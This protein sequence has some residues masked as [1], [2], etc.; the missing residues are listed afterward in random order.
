MP[1]PDKR[2]EAAIEA[3]ARDAFAHDDD[4]PTDAAVWAELSE[5][6]R[7]RYRKEARAAYDAARG[8]PKHFEWPER[9]ELGEHQKTTCG[10]ELADC[11]H[12]SYRKEVTCIVCLQRIADALYGTPFAALAE[13]PEPR[14][15]QPVAEQTPEQVAAEL[16]LSAPAGS[17]PGEQDQ[18]VDRAAGAE[19]TVKIEVGQTWRH[20]STGDYE[21]LF[22][23]LDGE[24]VVR[25]GDTRRLR[26]D[27]FR[28]NFTPPP[29]AVAAE[30]PETSEREVKLTSEQ[31][32]TDQQGDHGGVVGFT[33]MR[34]EQPDAPTDA[35]ALIEAGH[36][37][38]RTEGFV[39][40]VAY[41]TAGQAVKAA[42]ILL[43]SA[44]GW[45]AENDP[46]GPPKGP[47]ADDDQETRWRL[48][49]HASSIS[50]MT[51][52]VE[53][54]EGGF[55][56][57]EVETGVS[58]A[59]APTEREALANYWALDP[60]PLQDGGERPETWRVAFNEGDAAEARQ[61]VEDMLNGD[62]LRRHTTLTP[63]QFALDSKLMAKQILANLLAAL[64]GEP[65]PS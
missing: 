20:H 53:R 58:G 41:L 44:A 17:L 29:S 2:R 64:K 54:V 42:L 10:L 27:Y 21:V 14:Q 18:P 11:K 37:D 23:V 24:L 7:D 47:C 38:S 28:A 40:D 45:R 48:H 1:N 4:G 56:A 60:Q 61:R 22:E 6:E 32:W 65:R 30:H 59:N 46:G 63:E 5:A 49:M 19:E 3:A 26:E 9:Y 55:R 15:D 39:C 12:T 16:G 31:R 62:P 52:W 50:D 36:A 35:V 57:T 8:E 51:F 25:E 33:E 13:H 34:L 43:D